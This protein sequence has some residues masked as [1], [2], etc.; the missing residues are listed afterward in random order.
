MVQTIFSAVTVFV[1]TSI[2]YFIIM[3]VIFAQAAGSRSEIRQIVIG[4]YVGTAI[5]VVGSLVAAYI[6]H[7][8]P[9]DWIVGLL[10]LIPLYLGVRMFFNR[11]SNEEGK[12]AEDL[13]SRLNK[14]G[15]S[16]LIWVVA[17][18][19]IAAGG[20]N[21]GI[22]IPYFISLTLAQIALAVIVFALALALFSWVCYR[23]ANSSLIIEMVEKT[24]R[25]LVPAVFIGLGV[26]ILVDNGT[27]EH[28]LQLI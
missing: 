14:G 26:Y 13:L 18:I 5:L 6:A 19:Y 11:E 2:D 24:E 17:T 16:N 28:L 3:T 21:V 27:I 8:I 20:D 4:Q 12:E 1:S 22:Y 10:G 25:W 15:S 23:L 9:Q 7:F